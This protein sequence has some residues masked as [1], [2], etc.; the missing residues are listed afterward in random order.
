MS[1][2]IGT[3][4]QRPVRQWPFIQRT[5]PTFELGDDDRPPVPYKPALYLPTVF[6]D[7]ELRDWVTIPKGVIV[8]AS[9]TNAVTPLTLGVLVPSNGGADATDTYTIN[10][11]NAGVRDTNGNLVVAGQTYTR[12]ANEPIGLA[13]V[14]MFQDIR[15][16]YLNY[17]IQPDALGILCRRTI[18]LPYFTH[19]DLGTSTFSV[20]QAAVQAKVGGLAYGGTAT[21]PSVTYSTHDDLQNGNWMM[22]DANGK[23]VKWDGVD[24]KQVVGQT[25]LV[26]TNYPKDLLQFVQTYPLSEMPGSETGGFPGLLAAVGATKAVRI[27]LK[28]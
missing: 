3:S 15:G 4:S 24:V 7:M 17:Q 18:E 25:I 11:Q 21:A 19:T 10:D 26:D 2:S 14:D 22:S 28:F 5:R 16:R 20:A 6:M 9:P 23:F 13:Y 1:E 8:S 12:V 27:R